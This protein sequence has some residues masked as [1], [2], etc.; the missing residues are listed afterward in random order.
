MTWARTSPSTC[1]RVR[2]TWPAAR[3]TSSAFQYVQPEVPLLCI[4][5]T[6]LSAGAHG[7]VDLREHNSID[8][9]A[10]VR[11][12]ARSPRYSLMLAMRQSAVAAP[13]DSI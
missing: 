10:R 2:G 1:R 11:S 12:V 9:P 13:F 4:T 6:S 7:Y 8:L 5:E 3:A